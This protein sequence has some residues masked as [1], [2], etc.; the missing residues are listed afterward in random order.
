MNSLDFRPEFQ[1]NDVIS[2]VIPILDHG[3]GWHR[4]CSNSFLT[5]GGR[6]PLYC[7]SLLA[8]TGL[9]AVSQLSPWSM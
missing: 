8:F 9:V 3:L 5:C 7:I 4:T 6:L 1:V 2:E